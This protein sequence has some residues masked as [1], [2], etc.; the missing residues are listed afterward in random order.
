MNNHLSE[1]ENQENF[2]LKTLEEAIKARINN[3]EFGYNPDKTKRKMFLKTVITDSEGRHIGADRANMYGLISREELNNYYQATDFDQVTYNVKYE[4]KAR[5]LEEFFAN[6]LTKK[7]SLSG[8]FFFC[9]EDVAHK[10]FTEL[11][12]G[13]CY[14][15]ELVPANN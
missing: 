13:L 3:G 14:S 10:V 15:E 4:L 9:W 11:C 12:Y 6:E 7:T 1:L 2:N 8:K 5:E